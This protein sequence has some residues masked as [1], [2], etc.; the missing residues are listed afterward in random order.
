MA[1]ELRGRAPATAGADLQDQMAGPDPVHEAR[2]RRRAARHADLAQIE[3]FPSIDLGVR[4]QSAAAA[5]DPSKRKRRLS[6]GLR[7][8]QQD[9]FIPR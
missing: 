1:T 5:I 7:R 9:P 6:W 4:A 2:V 3:L 8:L